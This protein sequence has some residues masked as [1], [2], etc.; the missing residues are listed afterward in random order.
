MEKYSFGDLASNSLDRIFAVGEE[1]MA[2]WESI[3]DVRARIDAVPI[4]PS[5]HVQIS[6]DGTEGMGPAQDSS[7]HVTPDYRRDLPA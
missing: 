6:F 5:G 3:L 2:A 1:E 4:V 7:I